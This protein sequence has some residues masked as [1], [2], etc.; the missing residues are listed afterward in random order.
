MGLGL[1]RRE[2]RLGVLDSEQAAPKVEFAEP[3]TKIKSTGRKMVG[4]GHSFTDIALTD[5][6]LLDP[7][8]LTG[9]TFVDRDAM[10]VTVLAGTPLHELNSRLHGLGLA[11]HNMGDIDR[12]TVAGA[13]S[14]FPVYAAP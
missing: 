1:D 5:G 14:R 2:D 10:T 12:Q 8:R 6:V 4:S 9:V 13:V 3:L 11:L 7:S